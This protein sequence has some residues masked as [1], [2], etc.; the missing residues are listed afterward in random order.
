MLKYLDGGSALHLN[1]E[2]YLT[3]QQFLFLLDYAAQSGCNYFCTNV[4][5]T[6]CN[7]CEKVTKKTQSYCGHC[8]SNDVDFATRVIG[9]QKE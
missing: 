9:D 1:L 5:V 6:V 8:G 3:E 7:D 2:E 4:K